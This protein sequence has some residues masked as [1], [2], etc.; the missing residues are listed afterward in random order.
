MTSRAAK[1]GNFPAFAL[2]ALLASFSAFAQYPSKPVRVISPFPAGGIGDAWAR[3]VSAP[4]GAALRQPVVV[5][6]RIG[7]DGVIGTHYVVKAAPDGYTLLMAPSSVV[8]AAPALRKQPPYDPARDLSPISM[9]G[10]GSL[11]LLVHP[12]VPART[13]QEL[14]AYARAHPDG[15]NYATGNALAA[16]GTAQL[17]KAASVRMVQVPYKGEALAL[18]DLLEGRVQVEI[19]ASVAQALPHIRSGRLRLLASVMDSRS[20]LAPDVATISEAGF[21]SVTARAWA[22]VFGP[23]GIP[24]EIVDRLAGEIG[25][26]LRRPEVQEQ[27]AR[28]GYVLQP[29]GPAQFAPFVKQQYEL[30]KAAVR[31]AGIEPE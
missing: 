29:A 24:R 21:P 23:A 7:A 10:Y 28:N 4:L 2:A 17:M 6:N 26:V 5:E 12:G 20:P 22:G 18:P 9:I 13:V 11:F 27:F 15:L 16:V 1:G 30:W 8:T 31:E 14:V 25:A 3:I 19:F